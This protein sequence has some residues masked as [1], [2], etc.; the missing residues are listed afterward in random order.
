MEMSMKEYLEG[1]YIKRGRDAVLGEIRMARAQLVTPAEELTDE[2]VADLAFLI[3]HAEERM[4]D[5]PKNAEALFPIMRRVVWSRENCP[6]G[7]EKTAILT[8][9][10]RV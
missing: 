2:D 4:K 1:L 8:A 5:W 10:S 9:A 7:E 3:Y 6:E